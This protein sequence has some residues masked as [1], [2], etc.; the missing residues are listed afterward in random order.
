M[1]ICWMNIVAGHFGY[2]MKFINSLHA[3]NNDP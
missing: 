2:T 1:L 3:G